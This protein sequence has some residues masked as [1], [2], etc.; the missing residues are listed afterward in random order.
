M[1]ARGIDS[2]QTSMHVS[3]QLSK[4][5]LNGFLEKRWL[6]L[7][8]VSTVKESLM[9]DFYSDMLPDVNS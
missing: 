2:S 5:Y 7:L 6:V 8:N 1:Q 4:S 3:I 9:V